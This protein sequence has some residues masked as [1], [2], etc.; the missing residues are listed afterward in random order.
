M[1]QIDWETK[2]PKMTPTK[3]P[4]ALMR[5]NGCGVGMYGKRDLDAETR[6]Y[7]STWCISILFAP[8]FCLRAYRVAPASANSWYFLGREPL[9]SLAKWWNA[10]ILAGA[11][12]MVGVVQFQNYISTPEYRAKRQMAQAAELA[13]RGELAN[14]ARTY[15]N[16]ALQHTPEAAHAVSADEDLLQNKIDSAPLDQATGVIEA[17]G[18]LSHH[19]FAIPAQEIVD[20]GLKIAAARGD[21]DPAGAVQLLDQLRSL[22]SDTRAI[23]DRRLAL[24]TQWAAKEPQNLDAVAPLAM[25][26][27][28]KG[29][30]AGAKKLLMP[31]K[32]NLGDGEGARVLGMILAREGDLDGSYKLLWPYVKTRLADLH[33]A[34]QAFEETAKTLSDRALQKLRNHEGPDA[35]YTRHDAAA[36]EDEKQRLVDDYIS[37]QMKDDPAYAR[38][39]AELV[40]QAAVVPVA[41]ELGIVM[42][43]Q[44]QS[45]PDQSR[46]NAELQSAE[47]V[48]LAIGGVASDSDTYR[49]SLGQVYYWLGKQAEGRKLF[50]EY[51]VSKARSFNSLLELAGQYRQLGSDVEAR[52]MGE[53]AYSKAGTSQERFGAANFRSLCPKDLDDKI[54]WLRKCDPADANVKASLSEAKGNK[55]MEEGDDQ[56]AAQDF[57]SAID[58]YASMPR[59]AGTVND[60]AIAYCGLF[61][62]NGDRASLDRGIDYFQ[63]AVDLS[64]S[65]TVLIFNAASTILDGAIQDVIGDSI[66]LRALHAPADMS[67]LSSLYKDAT[68]RAAV[69]AKLKSHPGTVRALS[70]L[71][72]LM[73]IAPKRI[74]SYQTV[75]QVAAFAHDEDALRALE[76]HLKAAGLDS[77]EQLADAKSAISGE[78]DQKNVKLMETYLAKENVT[79]AAVRSRGD[80]TTAA[81]I[82]SVVATMLSLDATNGGQDADQIVN[83]AQ[84]AERISPSG[85]ATGLINAALFN[86]AV[87]RLRKSDPGFDAFAAK[88]ARQMGRLF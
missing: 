59:T 39:Q 8:V 69:V 73:V 24:L 64:P 45:Q 63:Q 14:A 84:E 17:C 41:M 10:S 32:D 85:R 62:A 29:D 42:L 18:E 47:D 43:N 83:L 37:A 53:E 72:K 9:S 79:L 75:Y 71:Q 52:A 38:S 27:S 48:F 66:D 44:A 58:A 11:L 77:S 70:Y 1:S 33:Q 5:L 23:D 54:A 81:A 82:D 51:L 57:Q 31:V 3:S 26:L 4:P 67:T 74:E 7:V 86:R 12:A 20:K 35:F 50:D 21:A 88:F 68:S 28:D 65:D 55:A 22:V 40:K 46:R 56:Q 80:R 49:L 30:S 61:Q 60:A 78:K 6:S 16:L 34:E 76:Q 2:F 15:K 25:L 19:D 36:T 13:S 87:K